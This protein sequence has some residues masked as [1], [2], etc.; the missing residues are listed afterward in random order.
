MTEAAPIDTETEPVTDPSRLDALEDGQL[1]G[2]FVDDV[3]SAMVAG[4]DVR[5]Q[6]LADP[7]H[8]ADIADLIEQ[9]RPQDRASLAAALGPQLDPEVIAEMEDEVREDLIEVLSSEKVAEVLGELDTDDAVAI[10]EDLTDDEQKAVLRELA[11]DDRAAIEEALGFPEESAGRLMQRDLVAVPEHWDVGAVIDF[12]RADVGDELAEDFYEIF[13]TDLRH[14][15]VGTMRLSRLLRS[16][17]D[18][19]VT[20]IMER[21]QTL[22]PVEM[23]QEEVALRFQK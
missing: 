3:M 23:D 16:P 20:E 9:V 22:I 13:V 8:N 14:H 7:L 10:V 19:R 4:D 12:L 2:S 1:K 5:V 17:R 18:M 6:Q 15:P 11:P 21:E